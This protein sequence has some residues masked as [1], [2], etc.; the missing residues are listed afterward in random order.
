MAQRAAGAGPRSRRPDRLFHG[1]ICRIGCARSP[2]TGPIHRPSAHPT[3]G[4]S[5]DGAQRTHEHSLR[6]TYPT[7]APSGTGAL[8]RESPLTVRD[9]ARQEFKKLRKA[10]SRLAP[11]PSDTALHTI[12]IKTKR[13]RYAAELARS[14]VGKPASRFLK[15]A[16]AVQDVLGIHQDALQAERYIRQFLKYST[17]VRAGFVAGRMVERQHHR[18]D[19]IRKEMKP[20]FKTLLKRG[21]KAWN[22]WGNY[23]IAI[24]D[25]WFK[26]VPQ[27]SDTCSVIDKPEAVTI[28]NAPEGDSK[29]PR[30]TLAWIGF[31]VS[32]DPVQSNDGLVVLECFGGVVRNLARRRRIE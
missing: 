12:R 28:L 3:S 32:A 2:A 4:G 25:V 10:I 24:R 17:S 13:A 5:A 31:L 6:G 29:P 1:R 15:S 18:R 14:S 26:T 8:S 23:T 11:S 7:A 30:C 9:L 20:L 22:E 21:R 27:H 16:R 19:T